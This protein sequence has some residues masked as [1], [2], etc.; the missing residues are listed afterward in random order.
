MSRCFTPVPET[1]LCIQ[2]DSLIE[3][4]TS[5]RLIVSLFLLS[6]ILF[7]VASDPSLRAAEQPN[8]IILLAD[9]L[10]YGELGCQ[11]NPQIPTP[12]I[13]SLAQEGIRFTQAYVTAPN[14][15][16]SRAG[17][18]TGKIPTRFGYEFNP[19]GA[20]NEDPGTGLPPAEQTLAELLHDQG[21]TTGLIG[22][23]HLGGAADY[24]PYRHGFDEFFGFMH[25]G[26]YFVPPPYQGVTTMLRRK[27]L[28]GG[29]KGRWI[30]G[31]LIYSTH[32]GYDEP[33]YDANNPIIRGG[34]PV[35]ETEYLTDA[36]TREAVSFIDR[37]Q[38]KPFFLYLAYNAVHSPLQGKQADMQRFQNI[39][40]VHRRIFAAMLSSLDQSVGQI[41][42]QVRKAKLDRNTLIVFLSDNGGP[43][44]ELTSSNLPL[45]GE[46]GSMYEGG[47]RV[48]FL[49]RWT[50][51]LPAGQT[52]SQ[53]VSSMDLFSTSAVLSGAPLPDDLDGQNLMPYLL[54]EKHGTPHHEF[55]WR[56]GK[57]AAL[58][59]GDWKIVKMRGKPDI[60]NWELYH[61]T[62]DLSEQTNL[63]SERQD[64]LQ[65][66][67]TR[68]N[69][70]N[71]QMKPALF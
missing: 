58:R 23:W 66:L 71:S 9:D 31:Q 49:M 14:C 51:K 6:F 70:L 5:M 7:P 26:H 41:L 68:W 1:A 10:G 59:L 21:Y 46:K 36:F 47:L 55:F 12:H 2:I 20:R 48:P 65:E 13:D 50:G 53:P 62:E 43:T 4:E 16:P 63:A 67:L 38:D 28:P 69:E 25:E 35:V 64:K 44:C 61:I 18:L 24:H 60:K 33:D 27:T 37:H 40:D 56:Q 19:I 39:D 11:G 45:R 30:G 29:S 32:L 17:L 54:K 22:K 34:Q 15:S 42:Q 57:R 3:E 8:I 52:Y